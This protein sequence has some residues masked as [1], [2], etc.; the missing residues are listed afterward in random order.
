MAA[1][2]IEH[3]RRL[4]PTNKYTL[5]DELEQHATILEEIARTVVHHAA[6][7]I[8]A[9][10]NMER[11]DA[12]VA[13]NIRDKLEKITVDEV[14]RSV[15]RSREHQTAHSEWLAATMLHGEWSALEKAWRAKGFDISHLTELFT[16]NYFAQTRTST[17]QKTYVRERA[18][19][20]HDER[21]GSSTRVKLHD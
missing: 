3:Y 10:E 14:A 4:L 16:N 20:A 5:D 11:V 15:L 17:S 9:K 8:K 2:S 13:R 21:R 6:A 18:L 12:S 19:S 1:H 7:V